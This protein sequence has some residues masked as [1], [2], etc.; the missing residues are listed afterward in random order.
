MMQS[1]TTKKFLV[2]QVKIDIAKARITPEILKSIDS[3]E[4]ELFIDTKLRE[5]D[6]HLIAFAA[7]HGIQNGYSRTTGYMK[8]PANNSRN[9][10]AAGATIA[11]AGG[12]SAAAYSATVAT[13]FWAWMGIASTVTATTIAAT[14]AAPVAIIGAGAY[15]LYKWNESDEIDEHIAHFNREKE[16]IGR[17]YLNRIR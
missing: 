13:G 16:K 7:Q 15:G 8:S 14:I 17:Y 3:S 9:A 2:N 1:K 10:I 5:L 12:A 6:N 4:R 11:T